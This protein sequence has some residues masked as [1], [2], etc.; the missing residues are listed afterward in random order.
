M[1]TKTTA[2]TAQC[3][4]C[5]R[6]L[7]D[8]KSVAAGV[9]PT[10]AKRIAANA[11]IVLATAKPAAVDKAIELIGDAGIVHTGHGTFLTV[12]SDGTTRYETTTTTCVCTAG[13]YGRT[14]YHQ[15]AARLI[16]A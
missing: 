10:C 12:S 3:K 1:S 9:G 13:T 14:C 7:R 8:P 5:G 11:V 4:R 16:A 6:T 15:I 2:K